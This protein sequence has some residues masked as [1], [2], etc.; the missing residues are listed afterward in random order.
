[1]TIAPQAE[2]ARRERRRALVPAL[3]I[4]AAC[5][6]LLAGALVSSG[7]P[8][9]VFGF[10]GLLLP[11]LFWTRPQYVPAVL[12]GAVVLVEQF[13]YTVG[14]RAGAP[15]SKVPL[16]H[17]I[18]PLHV[19]A[20]DLLLAA[21]VLIWLLRQVPNGPLPWPRTPVARRVLLLLGAVAFGIVVGVARHGD[22]R[23]AFTE[24]R[25]YFYLS[26]TYL[27][28]SVLLTNRKGLRAV[29][30]VFVLG[31]A[32]KALL[33]V[34]L[35]VQVRHVQPRPEA[36]LGHEESF[37]F[38]LYALLVLGLW[39]FGVEGRLRKVAV[40]LLPLVLLGDLVNS[41]RVA[42]LILGAGGLVMLVVGF[43][44]VPA[45]RKRVGL[46]LVGLAVASAVYLPLYW[47]KTGSLAQPARAV[48]AQ[49]APSERDASSDLYREQENA[50]LRLNIRQGGVIGK[51]FGVPIDYALPIPDISDIDPL[52]THI[53]HD[54]V[55]YVFMRMGVLGGFAFWSLLG[56]G[57]VTAG[58][59]ARSGDR[60][61]AFLGALVVCAL[62]SYALMGYN[63]QG[64]FFYRIA[65][66][67][68]S[69]LGMADAA[70][71]WHRQGEL[72]DRRPVAG[73][74]AARTV[75]LVRA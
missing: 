19:N 52:I 67:M 1:M 46:L 26:V 50:N 41:R 9:A 5:M 49:I 60:E 71:R 54:G 10:T 23:T 44:C 21:V 64:F 22:V 24:I 13:P 33:G 8:A 20:A 42:F 58:R 28:A 30:W 31:T 7:Q 57:M 3:V 43:A 25:P 14:P 16:F 73:R 11:V 27:L 2:L 37:F 34:M 70:M 35:F 59:L 39:V 32:F 4:G 12:V 17:G 62:I 6:G 72:E 38:G 29:L 63:D 65:F 55:L 66:T 61:L 18:G 51:G 53:P 48:R 68:G 75:V 36:V 69:L 56:V 15:T 40:W 47:N 45:C 74:A